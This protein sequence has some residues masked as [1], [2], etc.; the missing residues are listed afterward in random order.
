VRGRW[1]ERCR[2]GIHKNYIINIFYVKLFLFFY[3]KIELF[4]FFTTYMIK[5]KHTMIHISNEIKKIICIYLG[6]VAIHYI[7]SHLYVYLCVPL[8]WYG[9]IMSP[10]MASTPHCNGL[11]WVIYNGGLT[12]TN[13]W[14]MFGTWISSLLLRR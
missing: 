7:A 5:N 6:W 1:G 10:F 11:R 4:L 2:R 13:M 8:S 12:I 14:L 9:V 3:G